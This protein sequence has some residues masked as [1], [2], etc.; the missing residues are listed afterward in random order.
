MGLVEIALN[1]LK[2]RIPVRAQQKERLRE[3]AGSIRHLSRSRNSN[4]AR[5]ILLSSE[6]DNEQGK[7]PLR[8]KGPLV[9]VEFQNE[10]CPN[11]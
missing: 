3:Q 2:S 6:R 11:R 1:V 7:G 4:S 9:P 8:G 5:K 10:T